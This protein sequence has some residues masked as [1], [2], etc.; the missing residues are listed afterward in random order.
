[1]I[2]LRIQTWITLAILLVEAIALLAGEMD[3][4]G[5]ASNKESVEVP[6]PIQK[7]ITKNFKG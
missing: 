5:N 1:M 7:F 3:I 6:N 4:R 2:R